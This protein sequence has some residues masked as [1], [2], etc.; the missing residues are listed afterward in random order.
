MAAPLLV[1]ADSAVGALA[2]APVMPEKGAWFSSNSAVSPFVAAPVQGE[3][4]TVE[5]FPRQNIYV[6]QEDPEEAVAVAAPASAKEAQEAALAKLPP[7]E[8]LLAKYGDPAKDAPVLAIESA[9]K[10]FQGMM[11]ALQDG[12]DEMAFQFAKQYV[13][14]LKNLQERT[15]RVQSQV[16]L[17]M[18]REG[19]MG[20][21]AWKGAPMLVED[22]ALY[23]KDLEAA[24]KRAMNGGM[25]ESDVN[26]EAQNKMQE[27]KHNLLSERIRA[28][29]VLPPIAMPVQPQAAPR[30]D[31]TRLS[32][33][34]SSQ[35]TSMQ[36][37][38]TTRGMP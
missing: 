32:Q 27:A 33:T 13:R 1:L 36:N 24:Q 12:D 38:S 19:M 16:G 6:P 10:P 14:H 8:R 29:G 9:P 15:V 26:F 31:L 28:A 30:Q 34:M 35:T 3:K 37:G 11:E 2:L 17:A 22:Q 25:S 4:P 5:F 20:E 7:R 23:Q 21:G 18:K